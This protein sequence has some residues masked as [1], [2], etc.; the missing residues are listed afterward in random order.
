MKLKK[1]KIPKI[2]LFAY[3]NLIDNDLFSPYLE[4][5]LKLFTIRYLPKFSPIRKRYS[6][7]FST[8]GELK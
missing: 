4:F 7:L 3:K 1:K 6:S 2:K 8:D 5:V